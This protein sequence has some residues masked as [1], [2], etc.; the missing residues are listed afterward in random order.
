M[1]AI[2]DYDGDKKNFATDPGCNTGVHGESNKKLSWI[3][4]ILTKR[5]KHFVEAFSNQTS[6]IWIILRILEIIQL[7][8]FNFC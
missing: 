2:L 6:F 3:M 7:F 8:H 1:K 5:H 4:K